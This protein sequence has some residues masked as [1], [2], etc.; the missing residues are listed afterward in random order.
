[1][2]ELNERLLR[3]IL[4]T[5]GTRSIYETSHT[6]DGFVLMLSLVWD[7]FTSHQMDLERVK[8]LS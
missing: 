4:S 5:E 8:F 2:H 3:K 6:I 7:V 1:M